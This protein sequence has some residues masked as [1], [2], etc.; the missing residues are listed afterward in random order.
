MIKKSSIWQASNGHWMT[1]VYYQDG[2]RRLVHKTTKEKLMEEIEKHER[3]MPQSLSEWRA[4]KKKKIPIRSIGNSSIENRDKLN[5]IKKELADRLGTVRLS[6]T[7]LYRTYQGMRE[8]CYC[9]TAANYYKYGG[10]G[11]EICDEWM[12]SVYGVWRFMKW[13]LENG[14]REDLSID[15]IDP[16]SDYSPDNCRWATVQEQAYN[17][18]NTIRVNYHGEI[19]CLSEVARIEGIKY[20]VLSRYIK[21]GIDLEDALEKIK[22]NP[23]FY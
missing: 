1:Y 16:N 21:N 17:K 22:I 7:S 5:E 8:R 11:V 14:Y 23:K 2:S 6:Q 20:S 10:K 12:H 15:R 19:H 3:L 13:S 18:R 9:T 4:M